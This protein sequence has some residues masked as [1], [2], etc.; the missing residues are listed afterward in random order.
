MAVAG[1][2]GPIM[3][4]LHTVLG[5]SQCPINKSSALPGHYGHPLGF[6]IMQWSLPD[7]WTP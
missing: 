5:R 6:K 3:N 4:S 7:S 1:P 2:S